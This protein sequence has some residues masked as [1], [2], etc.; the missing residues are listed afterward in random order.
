MKFKKIYILLFCAL[1]FNSCKENREL[2][3]QVGAASATI[4]PEIGAFIAGDK[5]NRK[6]TSIHDD[7]FAKAVVINDGET[8]IAIVTIDC[9]GLLYP[10]VQR[11][12][13]R[14]SELVSISPEKVIVTSNHI[15][16]G[17]DVVGI[18]G[19]TQIKSGV[20]PKYINLL[21]ETAAQQ[22]A[23]AYQSMVPTDT[24]Y[25]LGEFG[26]G[27]VHNISEPQEID[28]SLTVLE[29]K[30]ESNQ[31]VATLSN[32][33]CHPTF[34][35]AVRSEVSADY[36]GA[37]YKEMNAKLE[38]EH[39]FLQGAIGGW[40]QPDKEDQSYEIGNKR[41]VSLANKTLELLNKPKRLK[42]DKIQFQN[43]IFEIPVS[44]PGWGQL[45]QLGVINRK[46]DST[47]TS[48][49]AWFRIGDAQFI[50]HPGETPPAYSYYSK[51]LMTSEPKFVLGLG[52]DAM[53][54]ILKPNYFEEDSQIPHAAYLS[55]MSPGIEA[56]PTILEVI[57]KVIPK[58]KPQ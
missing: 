17:P 54:Y 46:I 14:A 7:L 31:T 34:F 49:V 38:G 23:K 9:I 40:V 58:E 11:I 36:V 10:E 50:T 5:Q 41:G 24:S 21:V 26:E 33:A 22:V 57:D 56:G 12:R 51:N 53:G 2:V 29:F 20:D 18:W 47:T 27:W 55:R 43:K 13:K 35:D 1:I 44:N 15:H 16:S 52:L 6:F 37:F 19:A 39:L 25:S 45:A 48:E 28:R 3:F 30:N 42:G 8:D 4:N 32:F